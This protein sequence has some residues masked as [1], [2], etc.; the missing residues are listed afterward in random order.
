MNYTVTIFYKI[1]VFLYT[2]CNWSIT[3]LY[4][5]NRKHFPCFT[6]MET[7]VEVRVNKKLK[8]EYE[9]VGR[10]LSFEFQTFTSFEFSQTSCA[11]N[12]T[13]H[14][15]S[16]VLNACFKRKF[17]LFICDINISA[18]EHSP[19]VRVFATFFPSLTTFRVF[20]SQHIIYKHG[21]PFYTS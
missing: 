19:S 17:F 15:C 7:R 4:L 18:K 5:R 6:V 8:W 14:C 9:P 16:H 21:K 2:R 13:K 20:I 3:V 10:V 1:S 11:L 12:P